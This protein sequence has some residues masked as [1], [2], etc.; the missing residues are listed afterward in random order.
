MIH[1]R[2]DFLEA[3][4]GAA[5]TAAAS[6]PDEGR[7][8]ALAAEARDRLRGVEAVPFQRTTH[9][10]AQWYPDASFGL[11]MHWGIHSVAGL[12]PS[13]AMKK[14][15]PWYTGENP[16]RYQGREK[17]YALAGQFNP[18][19][20][21]PDKWLAAARQAGMHYAVLTAKHHDGYCLWPTEYGDYN[22][23]V[24]MK[25]RDLLGP[26]IE[27]CRKHGV[28]AGFYFSGPDWSFPGYPVSMDEA[29]S[30][31]PQP[32]AKP[33][34]Q[35]AYERH[36]TG[37]LSEV[38][39]RYGHID[40]IWF[41]GE[42]VNFNRT[43]AW[44][45]QLQPHIVI[46]RVGDIAN[47][48]ESGHKPTEPPEGWWEHCMYLGG[49]WGN[50]PAY[51]IEPAT[52]ILE[53]LVLTRAWGGNFL[54]NLGPRPDGTMRPEFYE[55]LGEIAAWIEHSGESLVGAGAVSNWHKFSACPVTRRG[56][57]WYLHVLPN[58][59]GPIQMYDIAE[60]PVSVKLLRTGEPVRFRYCLQRVAMDLPYSQRGK[61]D[62][63]IAVAFEREPHPKGERY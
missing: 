22:T 12:D 30:Y 25:G 23:R 58:Q 34:D 14:N 51:D 50:S 46:G 52:V 17:Y 20:Y 28:K 57:T 42:P 32:G 8:R 44:I 45:R 4:F 29:V 5:L 13:W 9:P 54:V 61:L 41:D 11:F 1:T 55:R 63:V 39:T 60:R 33:F 31:T 48:F 59:F 53:R 40:L 37:Q 49:H 26:F 6:T 15:I 7:N 27:A 21:D 19:N 35:V 16:E 24:Y 38:L 36:V 56:T 2:R 43:C 10:E 18:R 3:G 47:T 62:E